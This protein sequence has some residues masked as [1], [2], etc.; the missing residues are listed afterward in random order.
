[1]G[2]LPAATA[3]RYHRASK[4]HREPS[5]LSR[6]GR[7]AVR[8]TLC[9]DREGL[10]AQSFACW[11]IRQA[12]AVARL[13]AY[14]ILQKSIYRL[15]ITLRSAV[16]A[17]LVTLR[18]YFSGYFAKNVRGDGYESISP[19]KSDQTRTSVVLRG[20]LGGVDFVRRRD[21]DALVGQ[22][23]GRLLMASAC[24]PPA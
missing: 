20:R 9:G 2:A 23:N 14:R 10:F 12:R 17:L 21:V 22:C 4:P 16:A 5:T 19:T 7:A 6:C 1:M 11:P 15:Q 13:T 18:G 3:G 8:R 24:L